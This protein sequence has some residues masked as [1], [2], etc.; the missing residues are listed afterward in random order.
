M[1]FLQAHPQ[2]KQ[3]VRS[4]IERAI[5]EWI[6]PV[7]DRSIK[8]AL[9]TS[10]QIVRKDFALDSDETRM[11]QAARHM[12]RHLTAG[13]AMIT[14]RDQILTSISTNLK[15]NFIS[16]M[17][18]PTLQQKELAEQAANVIAA[19]NMELACAFVQ[20]TAIEKAVPE[21]DKRLM[22][23]F[24]LRKIARQEGRRYFDPLIKYQAERMPEPIKLKLTGVTPQQMAVYEEFA[25]NIP[26]FQPLSD[27][28][29]RALFMPKPISV[30]LDNLYFNLLF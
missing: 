20:K 24:E 10:E 22:N 13:M 5:Q 12:V 4:A 26:G 3:F 17:I 21:M 18:G 11:R 30:S 7:V 1:P 14:C 16:A 19:D 8:I 23:E 15:Q 29:S 9:T 2:L 28:D 25:R 27:R 6:H